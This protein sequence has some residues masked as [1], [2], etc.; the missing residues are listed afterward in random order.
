M[1]RLRSGLRYCG[2]PGTE[3]EN[4]EATIR[5]E[6][7]LLRLPGWTGLSTTG[8]RGVGDRAEPEWL[9]LTRRMA[10]QIIRNQLRAS[11]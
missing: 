1:R 7:A 2:L 4:T 3:H 9:N 5:L 6:S 11:T 8:L 10:D